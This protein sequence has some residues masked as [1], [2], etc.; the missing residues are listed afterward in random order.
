MGDL[1]SPVSNLLGGYLGVEILRP[2]F[3]LR[4]TCL[5]LVSVHCFF[6]RACLD[7]GRLPLDDGRDRGLQQNAPY[8]PRF[9]STSILLPASSFGLFHSGVGKEEEASPSTRTVRGGF[10]MTRFVR[11]WL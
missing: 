4:M 2:F 11:G 10:G 8:A 3:G 1:G 9:V 6:P 5:V 7:Q